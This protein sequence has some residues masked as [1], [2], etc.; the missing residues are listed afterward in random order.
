MQGYQ[1]KSVPLL[2][3]AN[4]TGAGVAQDPVG[5]Y[6]TFQASG[7]TSAGV[8]A[9]TILIEV[10]DALTRP[11]SNAQFMTMGTITLTLG[12]TTTADG[13]ASDAAWRW[14]RA[15][16]TAISGTDAAVTVLMGG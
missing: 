1:R 14:V 9:A 10:S 6:R 5:T 15:R 11:T 16:I 13:F 2:E 4:A 8:G 3:A 7:A 12:T